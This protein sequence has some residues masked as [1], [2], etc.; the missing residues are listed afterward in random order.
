MGQMGVVDP[1]RFPYPDKKQFSFYSHVHKTFSRIDYF[2]IDSCLLPTV[3]N[4]KYST[5]VIS[6]HAPLLLDLSLSLFKKTQTRWRFNCTL[7]NDNVFCK[8]I[9]GV[10]DDFLAANISS[11][12]SPSLLWETLKAVV[13]GEIISYSARQNKL[14]RRK[15]EQ[16]MESISELDKKLFVSPSP[17]LDKDRQNLQMNYNLL[18]T[19]QTEKMLLRSRGFLYEHGEKAG[20]HLSR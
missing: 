9:C 20:R 16:L 7:L 11:S 10:I 18:S 14:R 4:I 2:C 1:W 3:D 6:D 13:Q 19:Q 5:I 8:T 15:Q 12:V 17:E